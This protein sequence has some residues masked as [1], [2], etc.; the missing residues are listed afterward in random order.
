MKQEV[1]CREE[2]V[3]WCFCRCK[4]IRIFSLKLM[5][6]F[7]L[8]IKPTVDKYLSASIRL[9][10][11]WAQQQIFRGRAGKR[12]NEVQYV[13][14]RVV[15]R[16]GK[17]FSSAEPPPSPNLAEMYLN[18]FRFILVNTSPSLTSLGLRLCCTSWHQRIRYGSVW[19]CR[20]P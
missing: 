15:R 8:R 12:F 17:L 13:D 3:S 1:I 6:E 10:F 7:N 9:C 19:F 5:S 20:A 14:E 18:I 11:C 16:G 4:G 2:G